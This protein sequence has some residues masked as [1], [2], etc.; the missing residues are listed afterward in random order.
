MS[1]DANSSLRKNHRN[2]VDAL[3][4]L[5][6]Y[7]NFFILETATTSERSFQNESHID[8]SCDSQRWRGFSVCKN[9]WCVCVCVCVSLG[10]GSESQ[11]ADEH[12]EQC[13]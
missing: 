13:R 8:I 9:D 5:K 11:R 6:W 3:L 12:P 2:D 7:F 4:R 1:V 10:H